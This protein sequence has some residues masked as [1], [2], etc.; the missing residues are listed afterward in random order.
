MAV[1]QK[2]LGVASAL[3]L[4]LMLAACAGLEQA[5][6]AEGGRLR[7]VETPE[8]ISRAIGWIAIGIEVIG[9]GII[10]V[11][12][13]AATVGMAYRLYR[14]DGITKIYQ[15]YRR[16]VGRVILLG[17]EYLVAA[18]IV[19]TVTVSPTFANLGL[20]A[21]IILVRTFLSFAIEIEINERWPWQTARVQ[22]AAERKTG[23]G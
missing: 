17:L 12:L 1:K 20:L 19:A 10:A 7:M 18:D 21:V 9:V 3:S 6:Q 23:T 4:L 14:G 13:F 11:G 16:I 5:G 2:W 8:A 22:E 15:E